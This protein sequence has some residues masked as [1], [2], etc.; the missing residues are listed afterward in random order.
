VSHAEQLRDIAA[1][2]AGA[3][4]ERGNAPDALDAAAVD[5]VQGAAQLRATVGAL[6]DRSDKSAPG[7]A[8]FLLRQADA[9]EAVANRLDP[10]EEAAMTDEFT[11]NVPRTYR[12]GWGVAVIEIWSGEDE[13]P[14]HITAIEVEVIRI[15]I[16]NVR[17]IGGQPCVGGLMS[18]LLVEPNMWYPVDSFADVP[19]LTTGDSHDLRDRWFATEREAREHAARVR[20]EWDNPLPWQPFAVTS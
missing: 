7:P 10:T 3:H 17:I 8:M 19:D 20:H 9:I 6:R 16:S 15:G 18:P 14:A 11:I 13:Q 4:P 12:T 1:W 5:I 2:M